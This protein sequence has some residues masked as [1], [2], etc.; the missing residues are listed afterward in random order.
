MWPF[1]DFEYGFR[2]SLSTAG[3]LTVVSD[4]VASTFDRSGATRAVAFHKSKAFDR[5]WHLAFCT[6]LS[7]MEFLS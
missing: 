6:N 3:L 2:P 1:P 7:L 5:V 4:R